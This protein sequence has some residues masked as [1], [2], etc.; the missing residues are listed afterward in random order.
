M[1]AE[2]FGVFAAVV[3]VFAGILNLCVLA[4]QYRSFKVKLTFTRIVQ[5]LG[6]FFS[7]TMAFSRTVFVLMGEAACP[8]WI[9]TSF[10]VSSFFYYF[11]SNIY[12]IELL[13]AITTESKVFSLRNM[14]ILQIFSAFLVVSCSG[15]TIFRYSLIVNQ[16]SDN[17][18][19]RWSSVSAV[20][21]IYST[22]LAF[23]VTIYMYRVFSRLTTSEVSKQGQVAKKQPSQSKPLLIVFG[24]A[25]V[26]IFGTYTAGGALASRPQTALPLSSLGNGIGKFY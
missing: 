20:T 17:W 25:Q 11:F 26:L 1:S 21:I 23:F 24:I 12:Y 4:Y 16:S 2:A 15:G 13:K 3:L 9:A 7:M 18:V 22:L 14:M 19:Y 8:V 10:S 6:H 5:T